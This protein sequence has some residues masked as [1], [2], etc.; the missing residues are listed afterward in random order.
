MI[1]LQI[2]PEII[3]ETDVGQSIDQV[4]D[5]LEVLV[6][7]LQREI[8]AHRDGP[9]PEIDLRELWVERIASYMN[10]IIEME[11]GA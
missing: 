11:K 6:R 7:N 10:C 2:P 1:E 9:V 3:R 5:H 4:W 8:Q